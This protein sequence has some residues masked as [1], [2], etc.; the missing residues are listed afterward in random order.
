[1]SYLASISA[2]IAGDDGIPGEGGTTYR[3]A[4]EAGAGRDLRDRVRFV[5]RVGDGELT[6]Y[7]AGCDFFVCPSRYESFGLVL[8]EA[9]MFGKPVIAGDAGGMR[10]IVED[11]GNGFRFAPDDIAA[12][13]RAIER[14]AGS[15]ELRERFG[16]RSRQIYEDRYTAE[17][18]ADG[19][20]AVYEAAATPAPAAV[21]A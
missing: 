19:T 7:Y 16:H 11:G 18:M 9:M 6:D 12:L 3:A 10:Y 13:T 1:M 2:T 20:L 15:A 14:L 21:G 17:R 5:G 4:F 8:L